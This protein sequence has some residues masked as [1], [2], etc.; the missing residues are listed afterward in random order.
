MYTI[1]LFILLV[2]FFQVS[3]NEFATEDTEYDF[4]FLLLIRSQ[5]I[6]SDALLIATQSAHAIRSCISYLRPL[7]E[8]L[9]VA[10]YEYEYPFRAEV[11]E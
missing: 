6:F 5:G 9:Y 3:D 8:F 1:I 4:A 11:Y 2:L 10:S 7:P